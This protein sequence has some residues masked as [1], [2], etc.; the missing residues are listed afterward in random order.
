[1]NK[2]GL[3]KGLSALFGDIKKVDINS[4]NISNQKFLSIGELNRNKYQPRTN[5]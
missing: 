1:M 2:R 5:F 3:G 4:E